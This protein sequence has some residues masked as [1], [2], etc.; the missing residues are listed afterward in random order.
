MQ[1]LRRSSQRA[2]RPH[3]GTH[4]FTAIE[5]MVTIA[6]LAI[7]AALAAPSFNPIIERYRARQAAEDLLGTLYYAR[8]EAMKRSGGI[9]ISANSGDWKNGWAVKVDGDALQNTAAPTKA[10]ITT[11]GGDGTIAADRWGVLTSNGATQF[12]IQ[13]APQ[14]GN[15]SNG[16]TLCV[17][18]GGMIKREDGITS[19]S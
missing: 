7:L 5:L 13:I 17:N 19:C 1:V 3:G 12:R 4:G 8:S 14:G 10:T 6:I 2:N 16:S 15:A 11:V 9:T 18:P